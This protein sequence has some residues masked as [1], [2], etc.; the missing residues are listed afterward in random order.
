MGMSPAHRT[1]RLNQF[2]HLE[3]VLSSSNW[4]TCKSAPS[5]TR[6]KSLVS[7]HRVGPDGANFGG[8]RWWRV[9]GYGIYRVFVSPQFHT[10]QWYNITI[11]GYN[12]WNLAHEDVSLYSKQSPPVGGRERVWA[13]GKVEYWF[14]YEFGIGL[15]WFECITGSCMGI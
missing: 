10:S 7:E 13:V 15:A 1:P 2:K 12:T 3:C 8:F 5:S 6:V 9:Q 11:L 14:E 4:L